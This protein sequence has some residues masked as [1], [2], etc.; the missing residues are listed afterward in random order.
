MFELS[1]FAHNRSKCLPVFMNFVRRNF[2]LVIR[3]V[4]CAE[5]VEEVGKAAHTS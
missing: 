5:G 2:G 3:P 1:S 4:R